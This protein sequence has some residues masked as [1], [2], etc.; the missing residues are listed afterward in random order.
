MG[1]RTVNTALL[2]RAR[3]HFCHDMAPRHV[4]RHNV[5][6]WVRSLR[7]LGNRWLLAQPLER[8]S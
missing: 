4:Q 5:R 8:K 6:A 2:K 3:L 1:E 7:F